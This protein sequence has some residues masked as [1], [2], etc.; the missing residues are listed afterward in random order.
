MS[1]RVDRRDG[2]SRLGV[3]RL[4]VG[5]GAPMLVGGCSVFVPTASIQRG[6]GALMRLYVHVTLA[7]AR[8]LVIYSKYQ[9]RNVDVRNAA[10]F[11]VPNKLLEIGYSG[12][13]F[14]SKCLNRHD[15]HTA[16]DEA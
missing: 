6:G 15:F 10:S 11:K 1:R 12:R 14:V 3:G 16:I 4:G 8:M 7:V 5:I 13:H 2:L 9:Y